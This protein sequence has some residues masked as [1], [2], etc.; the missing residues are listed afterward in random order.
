METNQTSTFDTSHL[1]TGIESL[2]PTLTETDRHFIDDKAL[3]LR[4]DIVRDI[5]G[6]REPQAPWAHRLDLIRYTAYEEISCL[7]ALVLELHGVK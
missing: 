2:T 6:G 1:V 3:Q 4:H 5:F 7:V